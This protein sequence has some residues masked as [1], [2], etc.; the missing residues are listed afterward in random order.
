MISLTTNMEFVTTATEAEA[1]LLEANL[2]KKLKPRFNVILRDDKSF[3]YIL[4]AKD[5]PVA[6]L[7]KHR[8]ARARKGSYYGPF[9]SAGAVNQSLN[10]LQKAFLLRS[11][12]DSVYANRTRPCLLYQIKRCSAP[13]VNY[14]ELPAYNELVREAESFPRRQEP[15][16]E[17]GACHGH[18]GRLGSPGF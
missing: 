14:I 3:P 13:C 5:H 1:L 15:D 10:T 11:C 6:Q 17:G 12:N 18:G 7:V 2:I 8:G 9:A 4:I 16:G